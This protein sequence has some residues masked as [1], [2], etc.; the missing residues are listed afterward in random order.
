MSN[1]KESTG[2]FGDMMKYVLNVS[3]LPKVMKEYLQ[4]KKPILP[5]SES[6]KINSATII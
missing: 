1:S 4:S 6:P 2:L 3:I 5:E